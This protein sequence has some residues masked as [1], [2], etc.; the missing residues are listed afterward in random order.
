MQFALKCAQRFNFA[1]L[2]VFH[3]ALKFAPVEIGA[4]QMESVK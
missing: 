2:A 3:L 4:G 1:F